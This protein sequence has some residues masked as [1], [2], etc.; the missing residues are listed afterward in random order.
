MAGTPLRLGVPAAFGPWTVLCTAVDAVAEDGSRRLAAPPLG[1]WD[2]LSADFS[3]HVPLL[4]VD[5]AAAH[6]DAPFEELVAAAAAAAGDKGWLGLRTAVSPHMPPLRDM[7]PELRAALLLVVCGVDGAD[8]A[9]EAAVG[10]GTP[11]D[12]DAAL[13]FSVRRWPA[14]ALAAP[15]CVRVRVTFTCARR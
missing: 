9:D 14:E 4:P 1:L 2:I 5:E 6:A 13:A 3:Y 11:E 12:A 7:D 10:A 8:A 15:R